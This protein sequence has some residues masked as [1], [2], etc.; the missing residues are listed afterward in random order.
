VASVVVVLVGVP[1][2]SLG[3]TVGPAA[4]V[5]V[6][7]TKFSATGISG[8]FNI[9]K[10]PDGA[11]WFTN[12]GNF[13]IGRITTSGTVTHFTDASINA[14][15]GITA[16]PDGALWFTNVGSELVPGSIG[17]ITTSGTVTHFTD[18]ST[19]HPQMITA[20]PDGALWF[21]DD[22]ANSIGRIT[23]TGTVS[24]FTDPSI[25][26]PQTITAGPD[27]ALWFTNQDNNSIGRITTTGTVTH[28][29][30]TGVASPGGIAAGPDGAL[31]FTN[32]GAAQ[33]PPSIG[34]ITTSGIVT[35]YTASGLAAPMAITAG[36]DG[37]LWFTNLG[38]GSIG[39]ITTAGSIALFSG[40]A[41]VQTDGI[42]VGP[43]GALWFTSAAIP[44]GWIGRIVLGGQP[45][46]LPGSG[47]VIE[48]NSGTANLRVPVTLSI[49][50][51][52]TVTAHWTTVFDPTAP[53]DQADPATD[54]TPASGTVTFAPGQTARTVTISVNG[55]NL[56][57]PD[58]DI[59]VQLSNPTNATIGGVS[60]RGTIVNDDQAKVVPGG[61][62]VVEGNSGTVDLNVP[63][64]LSNPSTQTITV[65]W[66]TGPA[67]PAPRAD[68]ASDFTAASGTV[69]F[70]AGETAKSVTIS[71]NGD[72]AVEPD[73]WITVSFRNPTN[74]KIGSF[75]GLGFGVISNDD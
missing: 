16:G 62:S 37:A 61:A 52:L 44:S 70:A 10:G 54:Y 7:V 46:I 71:V 66:T 31:W 40:P 75:Y 9:A 4:A 72:T 51:T 36:P 29:T 26:N 19:I 49:A 59:V 55:D 67:G 24:H 22:G 28:L 74:A 21:T 73:E 60:G 20:G 34:R 14:P 35:N 43:D 58:E 12:D 2:L 39:R 6:T 11:L 13:S 64:T 63:V 38:S 1:M 57:E 18:P 30:G 47:S 3:L 65:D 8:P 42:A 32:L 48:G 45:T 33:T 50:S 25:S 56:V 68:P 5:G 27:G 17:R 41:L 69:T 23:T 15:F 53:G